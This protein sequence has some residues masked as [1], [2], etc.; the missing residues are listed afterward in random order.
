MMEKEARKLVTKAGRELSE[1]GL[2]ARTWGNV[3]CR[4][5]EEYFVITPSGRDYMTLRED[6]IVKLDIEEMNYEGDIKPSS[7]KKIHRAIYSLKEDAG[8]II[9]TH[10]HN[11]SAVSAMGRDIVNGIPCAAYGLPG[12]RKVTANVTRAFEEYDT[13]AVII[14]NHGAVVYGEDYE[15]AFAVAKDLENS[16]GD[17]LE[18]LGIDPWRGDDEHFG[19]LWNDD[20]VI[21]KFMEVRSRMLPYLD[22]FAQI[23]GTHLKVVDYDEKTIAAARARKKPLLVRGRGA[24][25][26]ASSE[27][28]AA[29]VS[30][31]IEKNARASLA[32]LGVKPINRPE[33]F[34]MRQ[35]Y[36]KKYSK[37][38]GE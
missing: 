32:G 29:A 23:I 20:P 24:M 10:Q 17:Y 36:L 12:T 1:T 37:L 38:K 33:S 11:A 19:N 7:E 26:N 22:D 6:E 18:S 13:K 14:S 30:M 3:S 5:D 31:I 25:C 27:D 4:I 9:H 2:I 16:C 15:E 21:L 28:D 8:F 34:I 35:V